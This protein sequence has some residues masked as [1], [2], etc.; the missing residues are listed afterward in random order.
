[1]VGLSFFIFATNNSRVYPFSNSLNVMFGRY[2][3][4]FQPFHLSKKWLKYFMVLETIGEI[5][6][7]TLR[8]EE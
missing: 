7:L 2:N 6:L 5:G 3:T 8:L 1:M 4:L